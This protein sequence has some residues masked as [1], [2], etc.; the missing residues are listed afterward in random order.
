MAS[1]HPKAKAWPRDTPRPR[2]GLE[3][4][5]GQG[6]AS[7][8]MTDSRLWRFLHSCTESLAHIIET[9]CHVPLY[10]RC[11]VST[12][13]FIRKVSNVVMS[14]FRQWKK[15]I[16]CVTGAVCLSVTLSNISLTRYV[17][18]FSAQRIDAVVT[19]FNTSSNHWYRSYLHFISLLRRYCKLLQ[20]T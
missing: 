3:T 2:R 4:T 12:A 8:T 20:D 1:R 16:K 9:K 18:T 17:R 14:D 6:V 19:L 7:S 15:T 11:Q 5:Q 10:R 13:F